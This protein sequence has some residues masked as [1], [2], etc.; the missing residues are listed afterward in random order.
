MSRQAVLSVVLVAVGLAIGAGGYLALVALR[1]T[2]PMREPLRPPLTVTAV[3]LKPVTVATP[4]DGFGTARA[5]RLAVV[6]AQV[7]GQ[8]VW[9]ADGLREGAAVVAGG[10]LVQIDAREYQAQLRRA[11]SQLTADEA[12]LARMDIEE[13]SLKRLLETT[14]AE[15][16]VAQREY[17]R[18][19]ALLEDGT[20]SLRE[21]DAARVVLQRARGALVEVERQLAVLPSLRAQ[22]SATCELRRAE[23]ALAELAVEHCAIVAPFGG[24]IERVQVEAGEQVVPGQPLFT[25]LDPQRIEVPIELPVSERPRVRAGAPAQLWLESR[26]DVAW[27][28]NVARVAPSADP[29]TRTFSLYVEITQSESSRPLMPGMFVR[30]RIEGPTLADVLLVPRSSVRQQRVF[31]C[32]D[33]HAYAREVNVD[34]HLRDQTV[35]TGLAPGQIVITSNL[36]ALY[37]GAPVSPVLSETAPGPGADVVGPPAGSQAPHDSALL[38][39]PSDAAAAKAP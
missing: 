22:Q 5:D 1:Q 38:A 36:D 28:G 31:V 33:R 24:R 25:L 37:D 13:Q 27:R 14:T 7:A 3:Q 17:D 20:S 35:I 30:A 32:I 39:G 19:R 29:A 6:G 4:I 16:E 2:P 21:L 23:V 9:V 10:L 34:Q 8:V 15:F 11:R 12:A 26:P 18:I